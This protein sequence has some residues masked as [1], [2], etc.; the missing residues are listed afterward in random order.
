M[1]EVQ[2]LQRLSE[3]AGVKAALEQAEAYKQMLEQ[4]AAAKAAV[5][6]QHAAEEAQ[7]G[8]QIG[9]LVEAAYLVASADGR[10]TTSE[11]E[12]LVGRVGVLTENKFSDE[13]LSAMANAAAENC[14]AEGLER[15]T[16]AVAEL[17][18]DP[19]LRRATL[20]VASAVGYLDG[21]VGQKEGLALQAL[22]R[23]FGFSINELHKIMGEAAKG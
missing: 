12:R 9:A 22:A 20:L 13:Q 11:S 16:H 1:A 23:A 15:R 21:G 4:E 7:I 17:L 3:V 5:D 18:P 19:E 2:R 10:Y 6:A 8:S 14:S